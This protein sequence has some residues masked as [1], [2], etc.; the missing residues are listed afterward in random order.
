VR[1]QF[2]IPCN[3]QRNGCTLQPG[4]STYTYDFTSASPFIVVLMASTLLVRESQPDVA[5]VV[6]Q[7]RD[8]SETNPKTSKRNA[9][10]QS[11]WELAIKIFNDSLTKDERKKFALDSCPHCPLEA[12]L[13]EVSAA[14][15]EAQRKRSKILDRIN[16]IVERVTL[17]SRPMDTLAQTNQELLFAWGTM[18]FLMQIVMSEKHTTDKLAQAIADVVQIFGRSEQYT[19]LFAGKRR[20]HE[21]IG[22]LYADVLN[23]LVRSA[24]F[25][26]KKGISEF[27]LVVFLILSD[28]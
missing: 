7:P 2:S 1:V 8:Q 4:L 22:I 12:F 19:V 10:L 24:K 26:N 5:M 15:D 18:K 16:T 25:Y 6:Q 20:V 17:Y 3:L 13:Q 11:P 28:D 23:L 21:A 9:D 27:S 14:Q